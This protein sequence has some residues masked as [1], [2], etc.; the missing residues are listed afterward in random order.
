MSIQTSHDI[1]NLVIAFCLLWLTVFFAWMIYYF[2]MIAKQIYQMTKEMR[3]RI[4]KID[5]AAKAFK[6][7]LDHSSAYFVLI[8]EGIKKLVDM[9]RE[10]NEKR[11]KK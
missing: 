9:L 2:A 5:E 4:Q 1:L 11:N 8:G 3:L 7:K 10:K 6:E